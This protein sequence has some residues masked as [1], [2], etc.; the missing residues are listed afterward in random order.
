MPNEDTTS[1][2]W[3]TAALKSA[4]E[5]EAPWTI[6]V[7]TFIP[8]TLMCTCRGLEQALD[9]YGQSAPAS[10]AAEHEATSGGG[11]EAGKEARRTFMREKRKH[12]WKQLTVPE[13]DVLTVLAAVCKVLVWLDKLRVVVLR[14][15]MLHSCSWHNC[16]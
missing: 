6:T 16:V 4:T 5:C 7:I 10:K 13:R 11:D 15:S 8:L 9:S 12:A 1:Q 3:G 2:P 14:L